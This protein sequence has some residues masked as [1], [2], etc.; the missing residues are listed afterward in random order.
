VIDDLKRVVG[1][2]AFRR[3]RSAAVCHAGKWWQF[4]QKSMSGAADR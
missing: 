2:V 1:D 4:M 3:S